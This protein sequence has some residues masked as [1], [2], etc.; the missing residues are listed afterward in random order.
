M[1]EK[2]KRIAGYEELYEISNFGRVKSLTFRNG[3][4]YRL[5]E[6]ILSPTDNGKGY[7]IISLSKNTKR[8]NFYIH[9]LVAEAFLDNKKKLK[10]V[11]H[12][13]CDTHNNC[14]NNLEWCDRS[15]NLKYSYEIGN[16]KA[17]MSWKGKTGYEHPSSKEINQYDLNGKYIRTYGSASQ[18]S[19]LT[20]I[21]CVSIRKVACNKQHT[22]GGFVWKYTAN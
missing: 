5:K 6:K 21:C 15:Y 13:D 7:L 14:V 10:E 16:H 3:T 18:A 17:P 22:A 8:K 2:W 12:I 20:G 4:T 19:K 9:R 1:K 11:N